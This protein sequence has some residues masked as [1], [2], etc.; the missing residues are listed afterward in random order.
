MGER[1]KAEGFQ[2]WAQQGGHLN[3]GSVRS[4]CARLQAHVQTTI[5]AR[6]PASG[7]AHIE[8]PAMGHRRWR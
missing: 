8:R 3:V 1:Y 7:E 6:S 2:F 4:D 5:T